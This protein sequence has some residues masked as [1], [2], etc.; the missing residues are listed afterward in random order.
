MG[1]VVQNG[2]TFV[3]DWKLETRKRRCMSLSS[4][5]KRSDRRN[6][7]AG[8][9]ILL[10]RVST[11]LTQDLNLEREVLLHVLDDHDEKGEL[12]PEGES[13]LD[14]ACDV[15]G[16]HVRAGYLQDQRPHL[17]VD[18]PPDVAILHLK[19]SRTFTGGSSGDNP[20]KRRREPHTSRVL[21]DP[22][23]DL[24]PH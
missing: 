4:G 8:V 13:R 15:S 10:R 11:A 19:H 12:D 16:G 7:A 2:L 23:E 1:I 6:Y 17:V 14:G 24:R 9:I 20:E 22:P 5:R 21:R 3:V 18:D